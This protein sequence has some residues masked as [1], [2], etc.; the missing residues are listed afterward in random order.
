MPELS[1]S[2]ATAS[3]NHREPAVFGISISLGPISSS[4]TVVTKKKSIS[5]TCPIN[6]QDPV[7]RGGKATGVEHLRCKARK[8]LVPPTT[9]SKHRDFLYHFFGR[10][11]D[12]IA[13]LIF[14]NLVR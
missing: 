14:P 8:L 7:G 10:T 9:L 3:D 11:T 4:N 6:R 13:A 1:Q 12:C 5:R 2:R